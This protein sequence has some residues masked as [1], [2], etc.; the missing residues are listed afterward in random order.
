MNLHG[1]RVLVTGAAGGIGSELVRELIGREALVILAGRDMA[2]LQKLAATL[3]C[4]RERLFIFA[5][6]LRSA[7]DRAKLCELAAGWQGGIDILINNAAVSDF[8]LLDDLELEAVERAIDTNVLAPIDLCRRLLPHLGGRPD[9]H[10]VNIGSV[11]GSIGY[12][13]NA[14]Y[15]ATKFALR[16]FSESLRR[17]CAGST[18]GVHYFAPRATATAFNSTGVDAMNAEL[19]NATDP[20]A[21]VAEQIVEALCADRPEAVFGWP[22]RLFARVNAILPRLVDRSLAKQ[23]PVI[24]RFA[25]EAVREQRAFSVLNRRRVG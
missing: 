9:A 15:A 24:D 16:G 12:A 6:D 14:V 21:V 1:K 22:E 7:S 8:G 13:G 23:R 20:A 19:G 5:G 3:E 4:E 17:E 25:R 11:F 10:I 2:A 18:V